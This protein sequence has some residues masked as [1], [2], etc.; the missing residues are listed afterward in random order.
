MGELFRLKA[1]IT[2]TEVAYRG[3]APAVNDLVAGHVDMGI[4]QLVETLGHIQAGKLR[5]LA[6]L[7]PERS[8]TV[9]DVP[10][11]AELGYPELSVD[12][13]AGF[14]GGRG[15]NEEVR[16]KIAADIRAIGQDPQIDERLSKFGIVTKVTGPEEFTTM[17]RRQGDTIVSILR[18]IGR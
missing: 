8:A 15:I 10:T 6:V 12:S 17:I 1:G 9:P 14:F 16:R 3:N 18:S 11:M 5:A 4:Q 2:W 7:G 13:F